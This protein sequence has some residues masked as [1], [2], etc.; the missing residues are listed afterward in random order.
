MSTTPPSATTP[1]T[2]TTAEPITADPTVPV[3]YCDGLEV[4]VQPFTTHLTLGVMAPDASFHPRVHLQCSPSF[5]VFLRDTLNQ[6]IEAYAQHTGTGEN[7]RK[8]SGDTTTGGTLP[9]GHRLWSRPGGEP[10]S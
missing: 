6:A 9:A 10:G 1:H 5:V 2:A 7:T 8:A 4:H 3:L